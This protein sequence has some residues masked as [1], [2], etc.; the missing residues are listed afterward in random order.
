MAKIR[1]IVRYTGAGWEVTSTSRRNLP[2]SRPY[3]TREEALS[4]AFF[5]SRM[6]RAMG[7]E[8][9]VL[10]ESSTGMVEAT[11]DSEQ[12]FLRH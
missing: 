10:V 5:A 12:V 9:T 8:V 6:L 11:D 2:A 4:D 7:D 3:Q 1:M